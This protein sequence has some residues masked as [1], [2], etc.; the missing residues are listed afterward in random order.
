MKR[1]CLSMGLLAILA[2]PGVAFDTGEAEIVVSIL[3]QL[4]DE[5]GE[6]VYAEAAAD[7]FEFDAEGSGLIAAAGYSEENWM[8]AYDALLAGY[9]AALP[10]AEFEA[11]ISGPM[12]RLETSS[13]AEDQKALLR[14]EFKRLIA[15]S[16]ELRQ[17]GAPYADVVRPLMP[18]LDV[19]VER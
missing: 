8:H 12:A 14:G 19:L 5:R 16:R 18:R 13:L 2:G 3:E 9:T 1:F 11:T 4:A 17:V 10:E 7:W 6:G 15:K